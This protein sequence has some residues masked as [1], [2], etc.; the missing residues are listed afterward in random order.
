[1]ALAQQVER[2][3]RFFRQADDPIGVSGH[4]VIWLSG[5]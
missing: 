3:G 4:L 2:F 5:H 1:M